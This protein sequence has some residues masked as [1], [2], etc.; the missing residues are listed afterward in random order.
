LEYVETGTLLAGYQHHGVHEKM[1]NPKL[2]FGAKK[3]EVG[4]V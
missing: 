3:A 1:Q 4:L 2:G